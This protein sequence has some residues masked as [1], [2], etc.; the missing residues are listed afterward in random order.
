MN[1]VVFGVLVKWVLGAE[2]W[3]ARRIRTVYSMLFDAAA[4]I[5]GLVMLSIF[6]EVGSGLL[7]SS[8]RCQQLYCCDLGKSVRLDNAWFFARSCRVSLSMA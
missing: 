7:T 2:L 6:R 4:V 8:P 3:W 5:A 1:V